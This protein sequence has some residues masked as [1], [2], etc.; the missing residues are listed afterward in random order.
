MIKE[1]TEQR[2]KDKRINPTTMRLLVLDH[3]LE[4]RAA[5]SLS[6]IEKGLTPADR[7][8]IYRTLKTFE[9]HGLVHSIEDGTGVPKYALC[10]EACDSDAHH[11]LHV[12]FYC[13]VCK[14]T[15]CLPKSRVPQIS[16]PAGFSFQEM[17]LVVKGICDR[18]RE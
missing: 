6:D 12:H 10:A 13:N 14:E 11:D 7:I 3:L 9:E 16:L 5:V 17:N 4:Q 8:T 15:F 1:E 2:L 18:C